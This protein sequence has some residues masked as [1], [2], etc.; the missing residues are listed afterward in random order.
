MRGT[1]F[2]AGESGNPNGRPRGVPDKRNKLRSQLE[3]AAP[4]LI[5]KAVELA[6][7][8]D[9]AALR[10]CLDRVLPP[11]RPV[12]MPQAVQAAGETLASLAESIVR[13][14]RRGEIP[15]D[16]ARA[17]AGALFAVGRLQEL[18][19]FEKR[20]ST[21]ESRLPKVEP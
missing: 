19:E 11:L 2:K 4:D 15:A 6:T 21:L 12:D 5:C 17:W 14:S 20:L 1:P 18:T 13:A 3:S 7:A 16:T 8:G 9:V 10:I